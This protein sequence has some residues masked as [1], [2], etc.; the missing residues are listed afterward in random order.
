MKNHEH[1]GSKTVRVVVIGC[2]QRKIVR[3]AI[4]SLSLEE[5]LSNNNIFLDRLSINLARNGTVRIQWS[6]PTHTISLSIASK[7]EA[8]TRFPTKAIRP[9]KSCPMGF[10]DYMVYEP[11]FESINVHSNEI[12]VRS[13]LANVS[14]NEIERDFNAFIVSIRQSKSSF[15]T[16]VN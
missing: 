6:H 13:R 2:S 3:Y 9:L 15:Q 7:S 14:D 12:A 4:G 5:Y 1:L 10:Y 11:H 16:H 8:L